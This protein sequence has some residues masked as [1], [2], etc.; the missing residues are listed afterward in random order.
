MSLEAA[1]K[2]PDTDAGIGVIECLLSPDAMDKRTKPYKQFAAI[3][4]ALESDLG[5]DLTEIKKQLVR[6]LATLAVGCE[7]Q[8]AAALCGEPIDPDLYGRVAGHMRRLSETLGCERVA[9]DVTHDLRG[10]LAAK[11][12]A[13]SA[14]KPAD[15][16]RAGGQGSGVGV[17]RLDDPPDPAERASEAAIEAAP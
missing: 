5:G 4:D 1:E 9:R 8:D 2:Q 13:G 12:L 7:A 16:P 11:T 6:R 17:A 10:Y 3:V 15:K 14:V